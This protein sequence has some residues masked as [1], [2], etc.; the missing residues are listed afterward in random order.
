MWY[1]E[2]V[3]CG[4]PSADDTVGRFLMN[5]VNQVPKIV[6]DNFETM[7]NSNIGDLLMVTCLANLTQSQIAVSEKPL[8]LSAGPKQHSCQSGPP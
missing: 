3:P 4:K 5:L 7:L 2:D 6:P 8:N 1:A